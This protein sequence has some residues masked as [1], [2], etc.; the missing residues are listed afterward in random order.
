M[1]TGRNAKLVFTLF[2]LKL[3]QAQAT[4]GLFCFARCR[5]MI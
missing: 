4:L 3:Y 2:N 5:L 1:V